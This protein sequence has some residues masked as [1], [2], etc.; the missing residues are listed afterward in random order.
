ME[1]KH[2]L[3]AMLTRGNLDKI[4]SMLD[5]IKET[6]KDMNT[7]AWDCANE[8]SFLLSTS[9]VTTTPA[10]SVFVHTELTVENHHGK[11][12]EIMFGS[13]GAGVPS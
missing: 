12:K 5:E 6:D 9:G 4:Y 13:I 1:N 8:I 2:H 3:A 10:T 11:H 7:G